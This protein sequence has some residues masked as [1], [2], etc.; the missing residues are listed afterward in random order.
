M[1][2][3]L[4]IVLTLS[5]MVS[6][7]G[8]FD[9]SNIKMPE[10]NFI[11]QENLHSI[12]LQDADTIWIS[13]NYGTVMATT[14]GGATWNK[15]VTGVKE[16]LGSI[17]FVDGVIGWAAGVKGT[18][19]HT[20]DGGKT[21][22]QQQSGTAK[23]LL[24]LFFLNASQGWAVG[25]FGT[26]IHTE[27]GG[28]TWG[29]QAQAQDTLYNDVFFTDADT[30]W[31]VGEFGTIIHTEDGGRTWQPQ[32]CPGLVPEVS[33]TDWEKPLPA[34]YGIYFSD[35]LTGWVVGMDGVII[36]TADGGRT[37]TRLVSGTDKP[38][39]CI[40]VRG[41]NGWAV[42][43]KGVYLSSLDGGRTWSVKAGALKTKFW[44]REVA[45]ADSRNGLIV[46]ARGTLAK[47]ADGGATW[48]LVSGFS[49]DMPEFGLADF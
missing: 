42:G 4:L 5:S 23:D 26:I 48:D 11:T 41:A 25:E 6:G 37:W 31:V 44:L 33:E 40:V 43:N 13:G 29:P 14:D 35:S 12:A 22:A 15:Q 7:C 34:L 8:K 38:L 47:T 10:F 32:H 9:R 19:V 16:M 30:G 46:G 39:Y 24:D 2:L 3:K 49:Y 21:W 27:D 45:F 36:S 18:V 17:C 20:S 1:L 28:R